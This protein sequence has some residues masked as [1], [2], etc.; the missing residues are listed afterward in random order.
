MTRSRTKSDLSKRDAGKA[1]DAF[2]ESVTEALKSGDSVSFTGFGKFS[3]QHRNAR[4]GVNPRTGERVQIPAATVPKFS[5]GS[6]AQAGAPLA[7]PALPSNGDHG[8]CGSSPRLRFCTFACKR[9]HVRLP[10]RCMQLA[11]DAADR[12]VEL[13][14]ERRGPVSAAEAARH[15]FALRH[16]PEAL[17]R[18][19]LEDVVAGDSRLDWRGLG[20]RARRPAR[21][22]ASARGGALRRRR[23]GDDRPRARRVRRS[24]RSAPYG[25][26]GLLPAGT[27]QTFVDPGV[28]L[29]PAIAGADRA[30]PTATCAARRGSTPPCA[31]FLA[32]AG[33]AVLVAHNARF[34]LAFLD[35]EVERLTGRRI[36]APVVDTAGL[37]RRLLAGPRRADS[38]SRS[39]AHF[40]GTSIEA[41]PPSAP[42]RAGDRRGARRAD[43]ARSGA[44]RPRPSPTSPSWPPHAAGGCTRSARSR[45]ARLRGRG[46]T[47]SAT[48]TEAG[49]LRRPRPQPPRPPPLLLPLASGSGRPSRR[50]SAAV[51][52]IEWRVL[53]S[54]LEAAIEELRLIRELR[55]PANARAARPERYVYLRRRGSRVR[56]LRPAGAAGAD[57][58]PPPSRAGRPGAPGATRG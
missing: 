5:A 1:V 34:D 9:T 33:D 3:P 41:L 26:K 55:P 29:P 51:E 56:R 36:A 24:A 46:S 17:A 13:V 15:L 2:L 48:G 28:P 8:G 52:L 25:S 35:R 43:R 7:G 45:S 57:P 53:G 10:S 19:L 11:F 58:Q 42:G 38:G 18:S 21:R 47:S 4:Q 6:S 30:S 12:L 50:R 32:F 20:R 27:F 23:P 31:R 16:A 14:E 40:F 54:E 37:A 22:L 44:G 49:A 39:L